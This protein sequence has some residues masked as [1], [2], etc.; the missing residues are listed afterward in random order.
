MTKLHHHKSTIISFSSQQFRTTNI[1]LDGLFSDGGR[2]NIRIATADEKAT[3]GGNIKNS[4][5]LN[6]T[7]YAQSD[8]LMTEVAISQVDNEDSQ[9]KS[10][11]ISSNHRL[12]SC[13]VYTSDV[14]F[15]SKLVAYKNFNIK[16]NH[17]TI[18]SG[19]LKSVAYK[20]FSAGLGR[21]AIDLQVRDQESLLE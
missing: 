20:K 15:P 12:A 2:I 13:L 11:H 21:G 18:I 16:A 4:I 17:T 7:L 6:L 9:T 3:A 10:I 1:K 19:D 5:K 14:F 8:D